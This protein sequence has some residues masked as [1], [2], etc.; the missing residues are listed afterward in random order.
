MRGCVLEYYIVHDISNHLFFK[1]LSLIREIYL[2]GTSAA[3]YKTYLKFK[4][5]SPRLATPESYVK[6]QTRRREARYV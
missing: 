1:S 5:G 6:V 2:N 4:H 3:K